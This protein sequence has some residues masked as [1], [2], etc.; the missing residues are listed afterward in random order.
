[1][2]GIQLKISGEW[3]ALPEDFSLKLSQTN[4]LFNDDGVFSFPFE[5]PLEPN[6]VLFKNIADPFGDINLKEFDGMEAELWFNGVLLY[7]GVTETDE[8]IEIEDSIP[9]R[10]LS[11]NGDFMKRI[12][13][14]NAQDIPLDRDIKL[15]YIVNAVMPESNRRNPYEGLPEDV[16]MNYTEY[17]ISNPYPIAPYCNVRICAS[18]E[19]G[20]YKT[21]EAKRPFSGVCFY[22]MYLLD[23]LF[24]NLNINIKHN[25]LSLMEDMN[26]LAFF[27]TKCESY[28]SEIEM[29]ISL[30]EIRSKDF[31]GEDFTLIY[32]R[33]RDSRSKEIHYE[34]NDFNYKKRE[35]F[36]T[37]KNFPDVLVKD[38]IEDFN[39]AF[40]V[41]FIQD[42]RTNS[43]S[44]VYLKEIFK[45]TDISFLNIPIFSYVVSKKKNVNIL[46]T[47]GVSDNTSF[48]YNDYSF[49]KEYN[50]YKD[51]LLAG[52]SSYTRDCA[53]DKMTGDAY[54]VKVN[55]ETGN[56]PSLFEVGG[57]RDYLVGKGNLENTENL[58]ISFSPVIINDTAGGAR[59]SSGRR[60]LRDD[61][62]V[63]AENHSGQTLAVFADVELLS[64]EYFDKNIEEIRQGSSRRE[65]VA[66][67][68]IIGYTYL[69]ARFPGKYNTDDN[70]ESPLRTY[71][72]GYTLGIMRGPGSDSK[73][74][75]EKDYDG[76]GNSSWV[77]TAK[78]YSFSSDTCDNY[79]RFFDYNGTESG[80]ADQSGRF[81]LKLIAEKEGFSIDSKYANRGL[82]AK[83][84]SEY[85]YFLEHRKT[86]LLDV[87]MNITQL[88]N[89]DFLKKYKIGDFVGFI[90]KVSYT[91]TANG[92]EN[93]TIEMYTL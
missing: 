27:T 87:K 68:P 29:D 60:S 15:G 46:L 81:S 44:I 49:V 7:K 32:H 18:N 12:E 23:L 5:V 66:T 20:K 37:N 72:A 90:N 62:S 74:E 17:N 57:F 76:E 63:D 84:L 39:N 28:L 31:C 86:V 73:L 70:K 77:Q 54:K 82:V 35:V 65:E 19:L 75:Y 52:I 83:F 3:V 47:Y 48:N 11:G 40:G 51:I 42:M 92:M 26:R 6:R 91:M 43:I 13:E 69:K 85:L 8:E 61:T 93:V 14:L 58:S 36:A 55:K 45:K 79:G 89:L 64:S 10:F 33:D 2:K 88:I 4:P 21:L 34:T 78:N 22:V 9:M 50:E 56:D 25:D 16:M 38:I 67:G 59:Y 80:G 1:M 30:S 71:D 41:R 24:K 53:I